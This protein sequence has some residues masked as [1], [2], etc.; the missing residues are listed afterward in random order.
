MKLFGKICSALMFVFL[1]A[2]IAVMIFFSFNSSRSTYVFEN[3]SLKWYGELFNSSAT[4][5]A[6]KNTL[7]LAVL[8]ALIATILGTLAAVGIF[9][10]RSKI[11]KS[12]IMTTTN[13]PMMNPDVVTGVSMMLLFVFIGRLIGAQQYLS[14]YTILIAHI[15]FNLPYVILNVLPKLKQ[16][17]KYTY[18]AAL[19]LGATP[20]YAF[21]KVT[22]PE[23]RS[24]VFS[25][26]LMAVTMS[27]DDFAVT[28]FTRGTVGLDTLSTYIYTDARKGGLTPELRP[29]ITIMFLGILILLIIINLRKI[30][31]SKNAAE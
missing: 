30:R 4:L 8:S 20:L 17:N 24:G 7:I 27:L 29:M 6:L 22:W 19:D 26:F 11:G 9:N 23:I 12:A 1:Y 5:N 31:N 3:F 2:P 25:G 10:M 13:I 18:E 16:T 28:F 15:T 21:Y 14:F